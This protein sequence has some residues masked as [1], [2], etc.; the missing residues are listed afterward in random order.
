MSRADKIQLLNHLNGENPEEFLPGSKFNTPNVGGLRKS[1][2]SN[3]SNVSKKS[4]ARSTASKKSGKAKKPAA[5]K[6]L[7]DLVKKSD[8]F[9]HELL[10][11]YLNDLL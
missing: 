3:R 7:V 9:T 10:I 8:R 11:D 1:A 6:N 5:I 2:V 4:S